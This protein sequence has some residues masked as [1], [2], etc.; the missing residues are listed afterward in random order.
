VNSQSETL[1]EVDGLRKH[2]GRFPALRGVS[3][4]LKTGDFVSIVGPNGAGKSTLLNCISTLQRP[5]AGDILFRGSDIYQQASQMRQRLGYMS[6]SLF[7]YGDLTGLENL[8]FYAKLY[9]QSASHEQLEKHL[10]ELGLTSFRKKPVRTYSR[11][12]KQ[13]LAI[14]RVLLHDPDLLLLDEPFTG[15]DQHAGAGLRDLL[16]NLKHMGKTILMISHNLERALELSDRILI[17]VQGKIRDS[18]DIMPG[19]E[20]NLRDSYF[21][22]VGRQG[23]KS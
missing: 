4:T 14:A 19:L 6:H 16:L 2:F 11:G 3:F 21:E 20:S 17:M 7:L 15:L 10:R 8:A 5:T 9:G 1:L 23:E 22:W 12:M 18:Q 13:R